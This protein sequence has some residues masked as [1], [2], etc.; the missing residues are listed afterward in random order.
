MG[1]LCVRHLGE[2]RGAARATATVVKRQHWRLLRIN[3]ANKPKNRNT[4][5]VV[6]QRCSKAKQTNVKCYTTRIH[7]IQIGS[8][9]EVSSQ[10]AKSTYL[11]KRR[12]SCAVMRVHGASNRGRPV[13][14]GLEPVGRRASVSQPDWRPGWLSA[15]PLFVAAK[16]CQTSCKCRGCNRLAI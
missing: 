6:G 16:L 8:K 14:N 7:E 5:M 9:I 2:V 15:W 13:I 4:K 3:C 10:P 12:R 11:I 1:Q